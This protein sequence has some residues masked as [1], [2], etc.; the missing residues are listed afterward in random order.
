MS[1]EQDVTTMN[2][3]L[4]QRLQAA[5]LALLMAGGCMLA[6]P[7]AGV[8]LP[9]VEPFIL[10][11]DTAFTLLGLIVATLLYLQFRATRAP[12]LLALASGFLLLVGWS[13]DV[14]LRAAAPVNTSVASHFAHLCGLLGIA[15]LLGALLAQ[16]STSSARLERTRVRAPATPAPVQGAGVRR[17]VD[18]IAEE[19]NQP[20]CAITAN[21]DAIGRMLDAEH[22]DVAE[23]RAALADIIDDICRASQTL[24]TAQRAASQEGQPGP[25]AGHPRANS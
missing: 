13:I 17:V 7:L 4:G 12:A 9:R 19:L 11:I 3:T 21:A 14:L 18:D 1:S 25:P 15:C 22:P 8:S 20:L 23:V 10:V 16:N 2:A 6:L 5:A 24:R